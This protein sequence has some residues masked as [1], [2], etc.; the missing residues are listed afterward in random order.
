MPAKGTPKIDD[1][2]VAEISRLALL[3]PT[4]TAPEIHVEVTP[5]AEEHGFYLGKVD[6]TRRI[7]Q[8]ARAAQGPEDNPWSLAASST[9][10]DSLISVEALPSVLS[11][12]RW[13][14][15]GG[16]RFTIRQA[17][18]SARLRG[19]VGF[20]PIGYRDLQLAKL[21][22]DYASEE[23]GSAATRQ[24][25]TTGQLDVDLAYRHIGLTGTFKDDYL[26]RHAA[27]QAEQLVERQ[28]GYELPAAYLARIKWDGEHMEVK[29]PTHVLDEIAH[30][31]LNV[32]NQSMSADESFDRAAYELVVLAARRDMDEPDV[33]GDRPTESRR[34]WARNLYRKAKA[35]DL[36]PWRESWPLDFGPVM[37]QNAHV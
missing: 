33:W 29:D 25:F 12:W 22:H 32:V 14:L 1:R 2:L 10:T 4:V 31:V 6:T 37:E 21:A 26:T 11:V 30:G 35:G 13:H 15:V 9:L 17:K 23:M 24:Q 28:S 36:T 16:T 27:T 19:V 7:M 18:W 5:F 34:K 3:T 8:R 20:V